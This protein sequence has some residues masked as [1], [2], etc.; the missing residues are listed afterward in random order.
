MPEIRVL[1]VEDEPILRELMIFALDEIGAN[2]TAVD[3]AQGAAEILANQ[4]WS[5]L[6]TDVQ[7]PGPIDG[8]DLAWKA[9]NT[10]P[11]L[12]IVVTSGYTSRTQD[13]LPPAAVFISKPWGLDQFLNVVGERI[14]HS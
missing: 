13:L 9:F 12:P 2:V 6:I 5:L 14:S 7:T 4:A 3:S 8:W 11:E 10:W 1:L